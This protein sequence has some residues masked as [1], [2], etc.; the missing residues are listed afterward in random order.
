M[1]MLRKHNKRERFLKIQHVNNIRRGIIRL[2]QNYYTG[3]AEASKYFD[4]YIEF[5]DYDVKII[6]E[7]KNLLEK[8]IP[9][10]TKNRERFKI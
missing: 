4:Q 6:K 10:T 3:L 5:K 7:N 8:E 1:K 2:K 9:Q